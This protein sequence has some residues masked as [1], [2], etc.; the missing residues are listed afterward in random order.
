MY[1]Y[2][3]DTVIEHNLHFKYPY[4]YLQTN[5]NSIMLQGRESDIDPMHYFLM[6]TSYG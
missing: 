1:Q 6:R 5:L 2:V 4:E 3:I